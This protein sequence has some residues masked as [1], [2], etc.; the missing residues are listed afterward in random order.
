MARKARLTLSF[1]SA[2]GYIEEDVKGNVNYWYQDEENY[3]HFNAEAENKLLPGTKLVING[4]SY[5]IIEINN[6]GVPY[7][8]VKLGM[9]AP[10]GVI[11]KIVGN[12][13]TNGQL[14]LNGGIRNKRVTWFILFRYIKKF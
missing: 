10:S 1:D 14:S 3:G 4:I 9:S 11:D 12:K 13:F 7:K 2:D 5:S 6:G 8:S